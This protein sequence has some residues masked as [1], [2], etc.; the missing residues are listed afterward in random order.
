MNRLAVSRSATYYARPDLTFVEVR[1]GATRRA[2]RGASCYPR[3]DIRAFSAKSLLA[4]V[5]NPPGI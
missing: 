3:P 2:V 5:R 4:A 1:K